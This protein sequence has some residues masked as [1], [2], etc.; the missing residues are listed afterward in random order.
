IGCAY[1]YAEKTTAGCPDQM[2]TY[3]SSAIVAEV[4]DQV[5]EEGHIKVLLWPSQVAGTSLPFFAIQYVP[6]ESFGLPVAAD[7]IG[8]PNA[9]E[10][11][12]Q[13]LRMRFEEGEE[14]VDG[15]PVRN[16]PI[17]AFIK[18]ENGE[19]VLEATVELYLNVPE[20]S[21]LGVGGVRNPTNMSSYPVQ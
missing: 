2:F 18:M 7:P 6:P 4:T 14:L 19:P 16:K 13:F 20:A 9:R 11:G 1:N 21:E 3:L 8:M 10:T 15:Q 17:E 12:P 5:T